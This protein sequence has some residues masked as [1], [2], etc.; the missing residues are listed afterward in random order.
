MKYLNPEHVDFTRGLPVSQ[1]ERDVWKEK[2]FAYLKENKK[3]HSYTIS[4]GNS[5]VIGLKTKSEITIY[6]VGGGYKESVYIR[7]KGKKF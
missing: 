3:E 1:E 7:K 4:T 5:I 6:D 2:V